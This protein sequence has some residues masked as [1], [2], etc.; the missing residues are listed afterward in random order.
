MSIE[1]SGFLSIIQHVEVAGN[2]EIQLQY[3]DCYRN[4]THSNADAPFQIQ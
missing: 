2:V 1:T 4:S 3:A